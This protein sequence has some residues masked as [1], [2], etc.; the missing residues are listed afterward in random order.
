MIKQYSIANA[1]IFIQKLIHLRSGEP[2]RE[3][4]QVPSMQHLQQHFAFPQLYLF[5]GLQPEQM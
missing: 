1:K 5:L 2:Q 4:P 3:G